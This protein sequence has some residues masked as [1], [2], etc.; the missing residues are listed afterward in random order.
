MGRIGSSV[1]SALPFLLPGLVGSTNYQ[2]LFGRLCLPR[3]LAER[4]LNPPAQSSGELLL[5]TP[6]DARDAETWRLIDASVGPLQTELFRSIESSNASG[7]A[8]VELKEIDGG[9]ALGIALM[10]PL[11]SNL[12]P[13]L[14]AQLSPPD[15]DRRFAA[16]FAWWHVTGD[17]LGSAQAM[18]STDSSEDSIVQLAF[19]LTMRDLGASA[20]PAAQNVA[21]FLTNSNLLHRRL[22]ARALGQMGDAGRL[23][24]PKL[25][26]CLGDQ[27]L[28]LRL[29]AA[30]A[31]WNLTRD[32]RRSLPVLSALLEDRSP[33]RRGQA[34][35]L[36]QIMGD[37]GGPA[38]T[39]PTGTVGASGPAGPFSIR[40]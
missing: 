11:C 14:K 40:V 26:Y 32:A 28:G 23:A 25:E 16:G 24:A 6:R 8:A 2:E 3:V 27:C 20:A 5:R 9:L 19:L 33:R 10:G 37:A 1:R 17:G 13:M 4:P 36:L 38:G 12:V 29:D 30:E 22:A 31:L 35:R 18:G 34:A 7:G 39:A 21:G 15:S